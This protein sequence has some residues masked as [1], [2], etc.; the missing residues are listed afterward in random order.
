MFGN[1]V[2]WEEI[3]QLFHS[4]QTGINAFIYYITAENHSKYF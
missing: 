2:Y 1:V 3:N 4:T